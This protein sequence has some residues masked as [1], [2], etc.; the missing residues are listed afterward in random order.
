MYVP[1]YYNNLVSGGGGGGGGLRG[2]D[3]C[4]GVGIV[5]LVVHHQ[6]FLHK[7]ETVRFRLVRMINQLFFCT[8][9]YTI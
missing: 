9:H 4:S 7:I 3:W 2:R 6:P 8:K 5:R 1:L